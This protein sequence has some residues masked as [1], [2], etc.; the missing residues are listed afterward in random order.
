MRNRDCLQPQKEEEQWRVQG[1]MHEMGKSRRGKSSGIGRDSES[2]YRYTFPESIFRTPTQT[3]QLELVRTQT[4]NVREV[5]SHKK[6][7]CEDGL[8]H[9]AISVRV[10]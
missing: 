9:E 4:Y 5:P 1:E 7:R 3:L 2:T 6:E 8:A 10:W